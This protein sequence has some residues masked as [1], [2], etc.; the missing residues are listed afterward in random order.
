M[1][2][3]GGAIWPLHFDRF[4]SFPVTG[5]VASPDVSRF[6]AVDAAVFDGVGGGDGGGGELIAEVAARVERE[7]VGG[8]GFGFG[9]GFCNDCCCAYGLTSS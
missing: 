1:P 8:G 5:G 6:V 7:C 3:D 4:L 9:I 2:L